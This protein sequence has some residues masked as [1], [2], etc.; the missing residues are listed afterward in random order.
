MAADESTPLPDNIPD[1]NLF[2]NILTIDDTVP[3]KP[4]VDN[5]FV[6]PIYFNRKY[7]MHISGISYIVP[8]A[9]DPERLFQ[10]ITDA[11]KYVGDLIHQYDGPGHTMPGVLHQEFSE[12]IDN[13]FNHLYDQVT[14][15]VQSKF[16]FENRLRTTEKKGRGNKRQ[17]GKR[18]LTLFRPGF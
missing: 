8:I 2:T 9:I 17:R 3:F 6:S 18:S 5:S 11:K 16:V 13:E 12:K 1:G 4:M 15:Y 10:N 7:A 14:G